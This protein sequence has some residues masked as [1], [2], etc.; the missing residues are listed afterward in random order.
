M[1]IVFLIEDLNEGDYNIDISSEKCG[2]RI[3]LILWKDVVIFYHKNKQNI[4]RVF[5]NCTFY[6]FAIDRQIL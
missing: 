3:L 2:E 6:S 4:L 1:Y 5:G